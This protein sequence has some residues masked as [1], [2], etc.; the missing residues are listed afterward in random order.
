M[1]EHYADQERLE[2]LAWGSQAAYGDVHKYWGDRP[3]LP[4]ENWFPWTAH[5]LGTEFKDRQEKW[6]RWWNVSCTSHAH[7]MHAYNH[8][9][10]E[11]LKRN[12]IDHKD[13]AQDAK[14]AE[15][16]ECVK[17]VRAANPIYTD[18]DIMIMKLNYIDFKVQVSRTYVAGLDD[19]DI[20]L[21]HTSMTWYI[22]ATL[23]TMAVFI[24]CLIVLCK[25]AWKLRQL[26]IAKNRKSTP[27]ELEVFDKDFLNRFRE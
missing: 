26:E 19:F 15:W 10:E 4:N 11:I 12:S 27:Q 16:T 25:Y 13:P 7:A 8:Y 9:A 3:H 21:I 20:Q 17:N 2:L 23:I 18:N 5:E 22:L 14:E 1:G 6:D 24:P